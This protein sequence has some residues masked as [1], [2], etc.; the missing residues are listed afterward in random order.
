MIEAHVVSM[1]QNGYVALIFRRLN[2]ERIRSGREK[3]LEIIRRN[4]CPV[5]DNIE[6]VLSVTQ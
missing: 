1:N 5:S 4:L 2:Q 6:R 3:R